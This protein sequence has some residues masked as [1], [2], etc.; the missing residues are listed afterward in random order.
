MYSYEYRLDHVLRVG[1]FI[2]LYWLKLICV[3][4]IQLKKNNCCTIKQKNNNKKT[5]YEDIIHDIIYK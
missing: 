5:H 2:Y 4:T 3:R 1:T